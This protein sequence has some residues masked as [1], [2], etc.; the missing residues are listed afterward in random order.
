[1][2]DTNLATMPSQPTAVIVRNDWENKLE[3]IAK[4]VAPGLTPEEFQLF[5]HVARVRHLDPLQRQIHAVKRNTWNSLL[6][7]G[8]GGFESKMTIQTGIDGY[9]AIANRTG[10]YMPSEKPALIED[11]GKETFRITA[12]IKKFDPLSHQWFEFSATA[13]YREFVQT[14]KDGDKH[15]PNSMWEKMPVNQLTKCA[16]ALA[17][18][19]GWPEEL[20]GIYVDE[21]MQHADGV[22]YLPPEQKQQEK[23]RGELGN[24]KQ[25]TQPNRG[26]GNEGM[27]QTEKTIC[28]ECRQTNG[29]TDDCKNNP[30]NKNK[31]ATTD[32]RKAWDTQEG[33]DPKVHI[34][35]DDAIQLFELQR[36]LNVTDDQI[37]ATLDREF[38]IQHRYLIRQDGFQLVLDAIR[39]EFGPK[40]HT[41]EE[42]T[43]AP[44]DPKGLFPEK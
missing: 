8:K 15:V 31:K 27:Q 18:R 26:H 23:T 34:S 38:E 36:V 24:M 19:K 40:E 29:H 33:H 35:F 28:A 13:Y 44:D 5:C 14:K 43:Q 12:Y 4:T 25:S 21:E 16:E 10:M 17:L 30:K 2:P 42:T 32:R 41:G 22:Q 3:L 6:N 39:R 37:R 1:M 20:G 7:N 11:P 9:R